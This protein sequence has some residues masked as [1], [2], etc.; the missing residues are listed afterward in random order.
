MGTR[1]L[2]NLG[3]QAAFDFL[4]NKGYKILD[5]NYAP[6]FVSGP[7]QG[8]IDIVAEKDGVISFVEVKTLAGGSSPSAISPEEKVD[9]QKQRKLMKTAESWLMKNKIPL[10]SKWQIDIVSIKA[11]L[12]NGKLKIR[13]FENA[14][15]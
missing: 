7:L 2:G 5:R 3:E 10:N 4:K 11:D 1:D 6:R 9:Y 13:H 15:F 12:D 8:E 14:V